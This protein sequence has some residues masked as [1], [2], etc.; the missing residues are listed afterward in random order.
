MT[1][2]TC[3]KLLMLAFVAI[4]WPFTGSKTL[5]KHYYLVEEV[6]SFDLVGDM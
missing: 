1:Q 5:P 4:F 6:L 3:Q 2:K